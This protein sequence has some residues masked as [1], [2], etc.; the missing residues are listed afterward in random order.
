MIELNLLVSYRL[1]SITS[2][3][4]DLDENDV[5]NKKS[6]IISTNQA[7]HYMEQIEKYMF[8]SKYANDD[9]IKLA[10]DLKK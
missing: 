9:D 3:E 4:T 10:K 5:N 6:E 8:Y 2:E 1:A 7:K